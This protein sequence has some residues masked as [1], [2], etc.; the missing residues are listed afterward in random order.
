MEAVQNIEEKMQR[1]AA[2]KE[3]LECYAEMR[4]KVITLAPHPGVRY[5]INTKEMEPLPW[6][7]QTQDILD[8]IDEMEKEFVQYWFP[9]LYNNL[10]A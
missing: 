2:L 8:R 4:N 1:V 6:P 5:N 7:K 10:Y 3:Y 9:D